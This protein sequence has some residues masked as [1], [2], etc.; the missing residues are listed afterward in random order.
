MIGTTLGAVARVRIAG[1]GAEL[2]PHAGLYDLILGGGRIVDIAP[3]GALP[4][5]GEVLDGD[6]AHVVPGLWDHHVHVTPW[7]L[8]SQRVDLETVASA[9]EAAHLMAQAPVLADGRRVGRGF[10]DALWPDSPTLEVLDAATGHVPTYLVNADL[11]SLWL[12]SAASA[13]EVVRSPDGVLREEDAFEILRRLG[14]VGP[15]AVDAAV[16]EMAAAAA[17][18]GVVGIVDL[19]MTWNADAWTRRVAAGFDA[20]HVRYG[21]YPAD[22]ERAIAEGLRSGDPVRGAQNDLVRVGPLKVI[23]DGSLGT[24]TAA[25]SVPYPEPSDGRGVLTVPPQEL[26]RL[27]VLATGIGISCA[28]HA[29]GDD[30]IRHALDAFALTGAT[31]TIE[32]A[33]LI[34]RADIAR[35]ARLGVSASVQPEHAVDDRDLTDTIWATQT[36]TPYPLR[37]LADAGV[38]L[39]FGSDAPVS[40]LD[41]WAGVAAAVHRSRGDREP[42]RPEESLPIETA[43]AA[44]TGRGSRSPTLIAAGHPADLALCVR[45]PRQAD[46]RDLR[47]ME[48]VATLVGGRVTHHA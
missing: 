26:R 17:A 27:M 22:L 46:D 4:L 13:R 35:F 42:W 9:A 44:S 3:T 8:A 18:R 1:P 33:Q 32:H 24:R 10:R 38:D 47:S 11:H 5:R 21:I 41:P 28:I 20:L 29:I 7:A 12:N 6:G 48:I 40:P 14:A 31:G 34:A 39:R 43:L 16:T 25:C 36:A 37:S 15:D 23:T 30:A 2:L 19:D 45:D